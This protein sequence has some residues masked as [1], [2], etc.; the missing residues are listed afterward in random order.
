MGCP[1]N[2]KKFLRLFSYE[3]PHDLRLVQLCYYGSAATARF[4]CERC[5]TQQEKYL[6][7]E[8]L[9]RQGFDVRRLREAKEAMLAEA[10]LPEFSRDSFD[11][12]RETPYVD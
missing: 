10:K 8:E 4:D 6:R 12:F 2:P 1:K 7:D 11:Q 9:I 3:G 5:G